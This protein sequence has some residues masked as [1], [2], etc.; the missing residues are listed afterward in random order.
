MKVLLEAMHFAC[1]RMDA[2]ILSAGLYDQDRCRLIE[3]RDR[4]ADAVGFVLGKDEAQAFLY[5][6]DGYRRV[7]PPHGGPV[8]IPMDPET[9]GDKP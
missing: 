1:Q 8:I 3:A 4:L 7:D 5:Q 2:V 9:E 6:P